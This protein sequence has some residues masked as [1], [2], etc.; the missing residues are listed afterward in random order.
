MTTGSLRRYMH[1]YIEFHISGGKVVR[2]DGAVLFDGCDVPLRIGAATTRRARVDA[3][4]WRWL[5][6]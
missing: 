3:I 2:N 5:T 6:G 1:S 4:L